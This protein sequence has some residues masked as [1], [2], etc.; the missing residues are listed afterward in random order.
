MFQKLKKINRDL[1]PILV[2]LAALYVAYNSYLISENQLAISQVAV[3]PHFYVSEIALIEEKTRSVYEREIKVFNIG[4]PVANISTGVTSFY[5]LDDAGTIGKQWIPINGY[6]YGSFRT[7]EPKGLIATH[8]GVDNA[9]KDFNA[10]FTAFRPKNAPYVHIELNNVVYVS[11]T[12][13][14][15]IVK[16]VCFF[17]SKKISCVEAEL[18]KKFEMSNSI[19]LT[20]LT[21]SKLIE[22][23]NKSL[24]QDT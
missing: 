8:K 15:D 12:T 5:E 2:S 14:D 6:Y 4:A 19:E 11:Y 1:A 16:N 7:G 17:N 3:E 24:K 9:T 23:Y 18:Y 13:F 10:T 21:Y 20:G 22:K